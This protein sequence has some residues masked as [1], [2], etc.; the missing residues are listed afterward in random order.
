VSRF[1]GWWRKAIAAAPKEIRKGLNSLIIL[2]AWE[3]WKHR[4]GCVFQNLRPNVQ[5]VICDV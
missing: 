2:V 4:N 5:E 1:S 3:V